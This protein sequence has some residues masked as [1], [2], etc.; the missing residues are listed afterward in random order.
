MSN[1]EKLKLAEKETEINISQEQKETGDYKKGV[2][3]IKGVEI[4]IENPTGSIRSGVD[5]NGQTWSCEMSLP[6]GYISNTLGSDGDELDVFIG[7]NLD[8]EFDVYL[9]HQQDPET[10]MF[11]EHKVMFGFS[12]IDDAISAYF[13][14][15]EKGWD[16]IQS[17]K[18]MS[19]QD[20]KTWVNIRKDI[21]NSTTPLDY[22]AIKKGSYLSENR[23]KII[24]L[25][26]EVI[27][28]ETLKSLQEQAGNYKEYDTLIVEIASNGGSVYEG[29]LIMM[30]LNYL[31]SENI[32]VV[33]LVT[34]NA[35]SIASLIMLAANLRL[36]SSSADI[37]VH[38]PMVPEITFANA[39]ELEAHARGLRELESQMYEIYEIFTGL[40]A[41]TMKELM[42]NETYLDAKKAIEY[43]FADEIVEIEKREKAVGVNKQKFTKMSD[44]KNALHKIIGKVNGSKFINQMYY[45]DKGGDIEIYQTDPSKYEV[46]DKTNVENGTVKLSDGAVLTIEEYVITDI[47][48]SGIAPANEGGGTAPNINPAPKEEL[49][50]EEIAKAKA[51]EDEEAAVKAKAEEEIP[52][53][54]EEE[55][56]V[57]LKAKAK[58]IEEEKM[59][60]AKEKIAKRVAE[61]A[62]APAAPKTEPEVAPKA[63]EGEFVSKEDFDKLVLIVADLQKQVDTLKG[64][65]ETQ[66]KSIQEGDEFQELA[67]KAID[68]IASGSVSNF[69]P[70]AKGKVKEAPKGS[71]FQQLKNKRGL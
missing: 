37:M 56:E 55:I 36:I 44:V 47:D 67:I 34:A 18:R 27:E 15:Y 41:K 30:W 29:L 28:K 54:T 35:Y 26:G 62:P 59:S 14:S 5:K 4:V 16:G 58:A 68:A 32:K 65:S 22:K 13:S 51:K 43:G 53:P 71:I 70:S 6:Y 66:A 63:V 64:T 31:S 20:F 25:E 24:Q 38:N 52:S 61:L 40:D 33:T 69:S 49:T 19:L 46:G 23:T 8:N 48:R 17:I 60:L 42:D 9:V 57:E 45:D 11:D 12:N 50:P 21:K 3:E 1:E 10:K 7:N 2:V 39:E